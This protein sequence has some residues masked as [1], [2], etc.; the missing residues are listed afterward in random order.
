MLAPAHE[1]DLSPGDVHLRS[2]SAPA[3]ATTETGAYDWHQYDCQPSEAHI[4]Q[5][6]GHCETIVRRVNKEEVL[7]MPDD[8]EE[9]I[10]SMR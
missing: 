9:P 3:L 8:R 4:R 5:R 10:L 6:F 1:V 2:R 7:A